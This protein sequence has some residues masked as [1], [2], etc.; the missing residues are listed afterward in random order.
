MGSQSNAFE[1]GEGDKWYQRNKEKLVLEDDPVLSLLSL[2]WNPASSDYKKVLE[3]GCADGWRLARIRDTFKCEVWGID[4]SHQAVEEARTKG[5]LT[6]W[7]SANNLPY[8]PGAFDVVIFG[9]CLYLVDRKELFQVV[10]EADRVLADKGHLVIHDFNTD[11][12]HKN[13]YKHKDGLW[14]YKQDYAELFLANPTYSEVDIRQDRTADKIDTL[15]T[16]LKK[17]VEAGWP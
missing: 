16:M 8:V 3:I 2:N 17:D 9:F 7:G 10:R 4:P 13:P 14:S 11:Y 5:V 1:H 12:P 6:S 15:T